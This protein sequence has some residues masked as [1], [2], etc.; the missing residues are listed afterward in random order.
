M[1]V[2]YRPENYR[3]HVD[4]EANHRSADIIFDHRL[5]LEPGSHEG[6]L[7]E[8]NEVDKPKQWQSEETT[9]KIPLTQI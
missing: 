9:N 5:L 1:L 6:L 3:Y 2:I 7:K 4:D 8:P